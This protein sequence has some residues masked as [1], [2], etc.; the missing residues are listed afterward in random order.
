MSMGRS[1]KRTGKQGTGLQW[2]N[3]QGWFILCG[4]FNCELLFQVLTTFICYSVITVESQHLH[5]RALWHL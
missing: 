5:G 4:E 3:Q 2:Q 1:W